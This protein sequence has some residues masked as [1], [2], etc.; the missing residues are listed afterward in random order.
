MISIDLPVGQG[1]GAKNLDKDVRNIQE[2]LN[3]IK[4]LHG[5]PEVPLD[6]DGKCGPKTNKAIRNFQLK[7]FGMKGADGLIEPGKQTIT[8]I[9][10]LLFSGTPID[11]GFNDDLKKQMVSHLDL[12]ARAV[13]AAQATILRAMKPAT[14]GIDFGEGAANDRLN[15][16]FGLNKLSAGARTQAIR[17]INSVFGMYSATLLMPGALGAGAFEADPTGDP[18]IAFTFANGFFMPEVVEPKKNIRVDRIYLGR[19]SF[20]ALN[21]SEF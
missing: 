21:D 13:H 5:G 14:G 12:V 7:Q 15:R 10:Q 19:R 2:A 6:V 17:N 16:H 1:F 18:R 3:K 4:P 11:P 20:F 8:R 9:N